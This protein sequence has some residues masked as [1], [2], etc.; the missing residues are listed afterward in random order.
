MGDTGLMLVVQTDR[1][2]SHSLTMYEAKVATSPLLE[3]ME[4]AF[5]YALTQL[6]QLGTL[7]PLLILERDIVKLDP[8]D[9]GAEVM[10]QA[11]RLLKHIEPKPE[12]FALVLDHQV[13]LDQPTPAILLIAGERYRS[14]AILQVWPYLEPEYQAVGKPQFYGAM[15]NLF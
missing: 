11:R 4:F 13:L 14:R 2:G 7:K 9:P 12:R 6:Q 10:D 5:R 15:S 3:L 1:Q 8:D